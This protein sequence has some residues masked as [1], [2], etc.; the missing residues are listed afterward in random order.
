MLTRLPARAQEDKCVTEEGLQAR[1][2]GR[3][4][5]ARVDLPS[6][7]QLSVISA[8]G[9]SG[10]ADREMLRGRTNALLFA[11]HMEAAARRLAPLLGGMDLNGDIH[12]FV[13]LTTGVERGEL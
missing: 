8:Y 7:M 5:V 10:S 2:N 13:Q 11:V 6:V 4:L 9:W 1:D 12:D 3:L